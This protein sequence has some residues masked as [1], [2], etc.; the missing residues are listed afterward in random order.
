MP[1]K[2]ILP[3]INDSH[4]HAALYGGSRPP[5]TLDVGFPAVRPS[6]TSWT[7]VGR[8]AA[9]IKPASGSGASAGTTATWTSAGRPRPPHDPLRPRR[10]R[11]DNP[12]YLV[13]FTQHQLVANSLAL[14]LAGI[15]RDTTTEPGS[16]VVKDPATGEPTGLLVE[17][18]AQGILMRAVPLLDPGG[19]ARRH[20]PA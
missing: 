12:V 11:P 7:S 19:K 4:R 17:L 14:K 1:G 3:G 13:D 8:R 20:P 18:P 5:L 16:E 6:P 9:A 15:T 2:T 10:G